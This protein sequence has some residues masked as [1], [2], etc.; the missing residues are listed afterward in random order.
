VLKVRNEIVDEVGI[1]DKALTGSHK[2][3]RTLMTSFD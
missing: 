1:A 2:A 3:D